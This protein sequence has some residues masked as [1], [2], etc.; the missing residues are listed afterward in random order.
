MDKCQEI[1]GDGRNLG[2]VQCDDG[3]TVN[4]DG[5]NSNCEVEQGYFCSSESMS[6]PDICIDIAPPTAT[7]HVL[8]GNKLI[9]EFAELVKS[10]ASFT[11]LM[12][13]MKVSLENTISPC[14]M[15]WSIGPNYVANTNFI[16]LTIITRSFCIIKGINEEFIV[17][18]SDTS[19]IRDRANNKLATTLV[20]APARKQS[21]IPESSKKALAAAG[22]LFSSSGLTTFALSVGLVVFQSVAVGSFWSFINIIQILSYLPMIDCLIP[23]ILEIFLTQYLTMGKLTIPYSILPNWF[24][25]PLNWL[26]DLVLSNL[27]ENYI[28]TGISSVSFLY[29]FADQ[30]TTWI[31]LGII[32]IFLKAVSAITPNES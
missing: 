18:F 1:C 3:N 19:L 8:A 26:S 23:Y 20:R 12:K 15:T 17:Q 5:C 29:N 21:Y 25:N 9:V 31:V 7:L 4:G 2:M 22:T 28:R 27:G 24:P 13:K 16:N 6:E 32:Y 11:E 30:L 14:E 10:T